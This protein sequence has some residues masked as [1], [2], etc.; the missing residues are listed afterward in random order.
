MDEYGFVIIKFRNGTT[1]RAEYHSEFE[2][3]CVVFKCLMKHQSYEVVP[4]SSFD[5]YFSHVENHA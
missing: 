5:E 2:K 3:H 1:R 4:E